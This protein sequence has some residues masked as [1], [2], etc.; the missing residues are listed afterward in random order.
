LKWHLLASLVFTLL[1]LLL[2]ARL[3]GA[4]AVVS[5][6]VLKRFDAD[7]WVCVPYDAMLTRE[8]PNLSCSPARSVREF[9]LMNAPPDAY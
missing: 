3:T 1:M 7:A 9:I 8:K 6:I 2:L 4:S 5:K